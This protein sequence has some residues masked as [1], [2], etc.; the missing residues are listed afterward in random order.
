MRETSSGSATCEVA[1]AV[2]ESV[3]EAAGGSAHLWGSSSG[4]ALALIAAEQGVPVDRLALWEAPFMP[5]GFPKPPSDQVEQYE[6]MVAEGASLSALRAELRRV[7]GAEP[8]A[9]VRSIDIRDAGDLSRV[10]AI[11]RPVVI[12]LAVRCGEVL[13]IDQRVAHPKGNTDVR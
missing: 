4:A 7:I 12:L 3:M 5:E 6:R 10:G 11:R 8:L 9:Q 13:L 2:V 1:I